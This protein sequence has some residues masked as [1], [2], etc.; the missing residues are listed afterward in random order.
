MRLTA[1]MP[2]MTEPEVLKE[3]KVKGMPA[4]D[5]DG[6]FTFTQPRI[7]ASMAGDNTYYQWGR[8]DPMLPGVYDETIRGRGPKNVEVEYNGASKKLDYSEQLDMENKMF[9]SIPDYRFTSRE[10]NQSIGESIQYPYCFL[11]M[12]DRQ[13]LQMTIK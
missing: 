6:I 10:T 12:S 4:P 8:K 7:V 2:G 3:V 11:Y 1:T 9:Y 5:N 13:R